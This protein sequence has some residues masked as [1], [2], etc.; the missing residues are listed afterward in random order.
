MNPKIKHPI[1]IGIDNQYGMAT[2]KLNNVSLVIESKYQCDSHYPDNG[3]S[4]E[5]YTNEHFLEIETLGPITHLK[6]NKKII[7]QEKWIL[8]KR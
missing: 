4:F 1:K 6:P 2:Y 3:S 7:H 5:F 8:Q